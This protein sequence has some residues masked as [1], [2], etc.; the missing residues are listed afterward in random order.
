MNNQV[1]EI[2]HQRKSVRAFEDKPIAPAVRQSVLDA[3]RRAPTAG[4]MMLYSIIE[5]KDQAKKDRL[6]ETCDN[7]PFIATAPW[8][9]LF[10][11]D[12]QRWYD[13][14]E[15]SGIEQICQDEGVAMVKPEE[16]DLMLAC[17][18]ALIAAQ[19]AVIAAESMDLGSCYIGDI[20]ENF[21]IHQE[22]FS[23]PPYAVPIAMLCFGYPTQ[24]QK[25]REQTSRF[26][27][28]FIV[29]ENL[30]HRIDEDGYKRMFAKRQARL[31]SSGSASTN[32]GLALYKRKFSAAYSEE[33]RRSVA[34]MLRSWV[35][36]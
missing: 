24:E 19:T 36:G 29:H 21:E 10:L 15:V 4:N 23:L 5:V 25:A 9:L 16:G 22:M 32:I 26:E 1:L 11:A 3:T 28:E 33:M 2:I 6:V 34:A 35:A 12:Y 7:Q 27:Q 30:Y 31:K 13:Y 8:V 14:F 18:D 20:L 17:C